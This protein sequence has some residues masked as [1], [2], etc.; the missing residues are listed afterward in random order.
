MAD[1][2]G[3]TSHVG[4]HTNFGKENCNMKLALAILA[5]GSMFNIGYAAATY[6]RHTMRPRPIHVPAPRP[7]RPLRMPRVA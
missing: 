3:A 5:L 1:V 7:P 2:V 4:Y 6:G